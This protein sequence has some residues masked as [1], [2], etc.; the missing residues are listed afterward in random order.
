MRVPCTPR[1]SRLSVRHFFRRNS[2]AQVY[3]SHPYASDCRRRRCCRLV[4]GCWSR[5]GLLRR[6]LRRLRFKSRPTKKPCPPPRGGGLGRGV[7]PLYLFEPPAATRGREYP[8]T[9][10][11]SATRATCSL[12]EG[13]SALFLE[14][15]GTPPNKKEVSQIFRPSCVCH[16]LL[17]G[18]A[19]WFDPS[20][21][22]TPMRKY[23]ALALMLL[24]VVA[25]SSLVAGP[26]LACYGY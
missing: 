11:N 25:G 8:P 4:L 23:I 2:H 24:T 14:F 19:T 3:R 12:Q 17:V 22:E 15:V 1:W 5:V 16:V 20:F 13:D 9:P 18:R 10:S 26:A 21:G 7:A 6:L